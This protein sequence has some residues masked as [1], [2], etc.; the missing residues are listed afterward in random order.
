MLLRGRRI[1]ER[2]WLPTKKQSRR[3]HTRW[4]GGRRYISRDAESARVTG[5]QLEASISICCSEDEESYSNAGWP[6]N[7]GLDLQVAVISRRIET[8]HQ[9]RSK[10]SCVLCV[11]G[12]K[13]KNRL[14]AAEPSQTKQEEPALSSI[15]RQCAS[16]TPKEASG[17]RRRRGAERRC[18]THRQTYVICTT[19]PKQLVGKGSLDTPWWRERRGRCDV[20]S[21]DTSICQ[22]NTPDTGL[23]E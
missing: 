18:R 5:E 9:S 13:Q 7:K 4:E 3:K 6:L 17:P 23:S 12:M 20:G 8:R 11:G 1:F 15:L 2:C 14:L 22:K 10:I 16:A 21:I 19:K